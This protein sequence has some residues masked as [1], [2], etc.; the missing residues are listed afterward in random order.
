MSRVT[1]VSVSLR[2]LEAF[3]ML[4]DHT[5]DRAAARQHRIGEHAHQADSAGTVNE[6]DSAPGQA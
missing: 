5:D 4:G 1:T 3:Q 6:G 2:H